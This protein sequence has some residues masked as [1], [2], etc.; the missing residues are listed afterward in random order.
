MRALLEKSLNRHREIG[1]AKGE[2]AFMDRKPLVVLM[3]GS[4]SDLD[5]VKKV[6]DSLAQFGIDSKSRVAS[7]HKTPGSVLSIVREYESE[8]KERKIVVIAVVGLSNALS[9]M[10][11]A[12]TALPV[13]TL[14]NS[15]NDHDIFSSLRMPS[16]VS[17]MTVLGAENAAL[18]AAKIF[19]L[20]DASL[21]Q[22]IS[23]YQKKVSEKVSTAD[24]ELGN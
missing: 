12:S 15:E 14:P 7:A 9:G 11:A 8:S 19:A 4:K 22:K 13:I 1:T 5:T 20:D 16:G 23:A 10:L 2:D 6:E 3:M 24:K 18:A 17:H 21:A